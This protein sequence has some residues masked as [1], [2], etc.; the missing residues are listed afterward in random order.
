LADRDRDL[1]APHR[2]WSE[3]ADPQPSSIRRR[4]CQADGRQEAATV[5]VAESQG[6]NEP[7]NRLGLWVSYTVLLE[8]AD[9][10]NA[11]A[12]TPGEVLLPHP[13][14]PTVVAQQRAERYRRLLHTTTPRCREPDDHTS[15][16]PLA[17]LPVLP[18]EHHP[19]A[20]SAASSQVEPLPRR[21]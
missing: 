10:T 18:L 8:V 15:E 17:I 20:L 4:W 3:Y 1:A 12:C 21:P 19:G 6:S 13:D 7:L 11:Q 16:L 5:D 9:G 2:Q 14:A